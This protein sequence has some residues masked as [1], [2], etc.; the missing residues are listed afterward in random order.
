M[1]DNRFHF[2]IAILFVVVIFVR[3]AFVYI[4]YK[5]TT[6][7]HNSN[8]TS[9]LGK[10]IFDYYSFHLLLD[11]VLFVFVFGFLFYNR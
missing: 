11:V 9:A 3:L 1:T 6:S 10:F 8:D 7:S 5:D 4:L 2:F